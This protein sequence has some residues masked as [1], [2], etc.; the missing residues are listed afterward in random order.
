MNFPRAITTAIIAASWLGLGGLYV[1]VNF[2]KSGPVNLYNT[3]VCITPVILH[4]QYGV[5]K[6]G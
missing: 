2:R 5:K 3:N 6:V 4:M 1:L